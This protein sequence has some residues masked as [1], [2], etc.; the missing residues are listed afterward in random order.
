M[1]APLL[2]RTR[3][4]PMRLELTQR[5]FFE[6][7]HT[8]RR[9]VETAPSLRIHGHTYIAEVTVTG[10]P[11]PDTGMVVDLAYLRA[12]IAAVRETLDHHLLDE[13]PGL[14]TATLENLCRYIAG[15]LEDSRW[16]L[17]AVVVRREASGDACRLVVGAT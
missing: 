1:P 6:A 2:P 14:G 13:V 16:R 7:A 11:D 8:L 9:S 4:D 5:F 17:H 15:R 3:H 10:E 12:A